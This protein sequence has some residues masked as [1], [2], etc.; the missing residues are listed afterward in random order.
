VRHVASKVKE[1]LFH[2]T[3]DPACS[4]FANDEEIGC[5]EKTH[6]LACFPRID[7]LDGLRLIEKLEDRRIVFQL[8]NEGKFA[9][10]ALKLN[11]AAHFL[12]GIAATHIACSSPDQT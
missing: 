3:L 6:R 4:I 9:S 10:M 11:G 1:V 5:M 12:T 7:E 2:F 8:V